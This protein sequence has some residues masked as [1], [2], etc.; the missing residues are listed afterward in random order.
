MVEPRP[1]PMPWPGYEPGVP[2]A[3]L[4]PWSWAEERLRRSRRYW[5]ATAQPGPPHLAALWGVWLEGALAFSTGA[6]TRKARNLVAEPHCSVSTESAQE[7]IVFAGRAE[8][9][10]DR[11]RLADIDAAYVAKYGS[12]VLVGDS[13]VFLVRPLSAWAV[14]DG[15]PAALPT[16]W[17]FS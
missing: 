11:E 10:G 13:P 1:E 3:R 2:G 15:D 14:V 6:L 4:L 7:G 9:V 16:R 5:L 17:R 12:T 8:V